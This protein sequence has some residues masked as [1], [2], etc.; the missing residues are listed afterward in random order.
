MLSLLAALRQAEERIAELQSVKSGLTRALADMKDVLDE[1]DKRIGVFMRALAK[2]TEEVNRLERDLAEARIQVSRLEK[3]V[4]D[5]GL[6]DMA[7]PGALIHRQYYEAVVNRAR[8]H[9]R[10]RCLGIINSECGHGWTTSI[11][12][13]L[14]SLYRRIESGEE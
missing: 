7:L 14:G 1:K 9:E 6:E 3:A 10:E 5:G 2:R 12:I 11:T 13:L 4:R 8:Q